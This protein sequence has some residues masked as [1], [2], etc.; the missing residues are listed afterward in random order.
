MENTVFFQWKSWWKDHIYL[1]FLSFP[2][3]SGTWEIWFF[4]Q[5]VKESLE[6]DMTV[7]RNWQGKVLNRDNGNFV[8]TNAWKPLFKK[9]KTLHWNLTSFCIRWQFSVVLS[10]VWKWLQLVRPKYHILSNKTFVVLLADFDVSYISLFNI[11]GTIIDIFKTTRDSRWIS[12]KLTSKPGID[13][14]R[15]SVTSREDNVG[16]S[17]FKHFLLTFLGK[18]VQ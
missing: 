2:W 16:K 1:V 4:V 3:Y 13:C 9:M 14:E 11:V 15:T 7:L 12:H 5:W 8:K 17:C 18:K 10:S 6:I